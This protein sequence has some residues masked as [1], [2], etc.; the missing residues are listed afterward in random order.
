MFNNVLIGDLSTNIPQDG[1]E[2]ELWSWDLL[3]ARKGVARAN[4]TL[5][6][7]PGIRAGPISLVA[8]GDLLAGALKATR[9]PP[10]PAGDPP[11]AIRPLALACVLLDYLQVS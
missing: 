11:H 8:A 6:I 1:Y 9:A 5:D 7:A 3:D 10:A 2:E 4:V